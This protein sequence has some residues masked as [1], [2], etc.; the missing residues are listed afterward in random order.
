MI[1]NILAESERADATR[2]HAPLLWAL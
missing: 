1:S 2:H